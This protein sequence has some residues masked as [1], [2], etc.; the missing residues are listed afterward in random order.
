MQNNF[1]VGTTAFFFFF[2]KDNSILV[3]ELTSAVLYFP[4]IL[5]LRKLVGVSFTTQN[6]PEP[7]TPGFLTHFCAEC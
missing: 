6:N 1:V 7:L 5:L 2:F 3:L 4:S